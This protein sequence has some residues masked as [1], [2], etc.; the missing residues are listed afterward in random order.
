MKPTKATP[1]SD[2]P[3]RPGRHGDGQLGVDEGLSMC[4]H[5]L[6]LGTVTRHSESGVPGGLRVALTY[7]GRI[8]LPTPIL[9]W[10]FWLC[11]S[12]V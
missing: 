11:R 5:G 4:W 6:L 3:V 7:K 10:A 2:A 8:P 12:V 9:G 1:R